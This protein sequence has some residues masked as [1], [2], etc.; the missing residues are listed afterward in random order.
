MTTFDRKQEAL[1]E[2]AARCEEQGRYEEARRWRD[3]ADR[4]ANG[5]SHD[6]ADTIDTID[7][8]V[9]MSIAAVLAVVVIWSLLGVL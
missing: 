5:E 3:C 4:Y 7:V 1:M 8:A 6:G 2:V 9:E